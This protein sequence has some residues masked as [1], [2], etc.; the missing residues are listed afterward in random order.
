EVPLEARDPKREVE[1]IP[2]P[3]A[4]A[5]HRDGSASGPHTFEHPLVDAHAQTLEALQAQAR[6]QVGGAAQHG[7]LMALPVPRDLPFEDA[8]SEP[9]ARVLGCGLR[10]LRRGLGE[11]LG[12]LGRPAR[13]E[14]LEPCLTLFDPALGGIERLLVGFELVLDFGLARTDDVRVEPLRLLHERLDAASCCDGGALPL[15]GRRLAL[16][17]EHALGGALPAHELVWMREPRVPS[18]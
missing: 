16:E 3:L 7:T 6:E 8:A 17:L 5:V 14:L 2:R 18:E 10:N 9:E 13:S 4:Q 15:D 11:A 12:R 1:L